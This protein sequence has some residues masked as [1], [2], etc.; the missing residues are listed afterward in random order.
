M[1][2]TG[3]FSFEAINRSDLPSWKLGLK[4]ADLGFR[5]GDVITVDDASGKSCHLGI[6]VNQHNE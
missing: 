5:Y 1:F 4:L 3:F 6:G 2:A